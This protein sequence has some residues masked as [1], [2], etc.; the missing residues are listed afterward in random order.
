MIIG[1]V[2]MEPRPLGLLGPPTGHLTEPLM[3][4]LNCLAPLLVY[5]R[6]LLS[7]IRRALEDVSH[8]LL[9]HTIGTVYKMQLSIHY[10]RN[11]ESI[12]YLQYLSLS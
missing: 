11:L 2:P 10:L 7:Q 6:G 1:T 8:F 3:G 5:D 9:T 12:D 4:H